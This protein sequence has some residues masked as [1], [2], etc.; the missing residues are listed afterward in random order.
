MHRGRQE[1]QDHRDLQ[2]KKV[3]RGQQ[4]LRAQQVLQEVYGTQE[5]ELQGLLQQ[6]PCSAVAGVSS[7]R[8][9]DLYLNTSTGYVYKCTVAGA[10]SAA[11]WIYLCSVKGPK[12]DAGA[13]GAKGATG[14]QGPQGPAGP[15]GTCRPH[16]PTGTGQKRWR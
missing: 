11:K 10:A 6:L 4:D 7:A 16:R 2:E 13:A 1:P 3:H 8:V 15:T 9:N 12:G 5:L 14:A